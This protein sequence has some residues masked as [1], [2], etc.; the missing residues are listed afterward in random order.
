MEM[1]TLLSSIEQT[2]LEM[3]SL[4]KQYGYSNPYVVQCSQKLDS[5]LNHYGSS[6]IK[7]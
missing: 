5:L 1:N 2:R 6:K 3:I 4:A 7:H